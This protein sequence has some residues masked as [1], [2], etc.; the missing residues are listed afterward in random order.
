MGLSW[1]SHSTLIYTS[2]LILCS[3]I[4]VHSATRHN[5]R[6]KTRLLVVLFRLVCRARNE[7]NPREKKMAARDHPEDRGREA[8]A[9]RPQDLARPP[10]FFLA[11][12]F[13]VSFDRLSERG[14]TRSLF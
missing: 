6:F 13:R 5:I 8:R 2:E 10:F 4:C 3:T 12:F 1:V 11:D 9:S 7:R 14:T